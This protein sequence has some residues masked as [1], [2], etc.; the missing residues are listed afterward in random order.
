MSYTEL[1]L[2]TSHNNVLLN[3]SNIIMYII[4]SIRHK[5]EFHIHSLVHV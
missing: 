4:Y 2:V 1:Y 3:Y 5:F